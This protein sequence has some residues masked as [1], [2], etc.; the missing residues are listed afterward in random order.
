MI[1][2][3]L[4]VFILGLISGSFL[5]CVI[6]RWETEQSFLKGRSFCPKCKHALGWQDLIPLLSF[7]FL[8]GRCRYCQKPISLQYPLVELTTS[9]LFLLVF[10]HWFLDI[11][12][13]HW[14]LLNL[15]YLLLISSCL[16]VIFVYDLKHYL[17]PDEIVYPA[18][19]VSSIWYLV[20]RIIPFYTKYKIQ[21]TNFVLFNE[22]LT[23]LAAASFFAVI[24]FFSQGRAMGFGD[25]KLAFLMGLFLGFPNIF[26]ALLAAFSSGA[27]IGLG[28]MLGG[29]KTLKSELPFAPFLVSGTFFALFWGGTIIDYYLRFLR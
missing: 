24:Y 11:G 20:F 28:L 6:Y 23:A 2:F 4:L 18:I 5:N 29:K 25:V 21:D 1:S 12:V 17:I 22:P 3:A 16:I 26:V 14:D 15:V 7:L 8:R 10:G 27:I 9:I 13:G 19:F